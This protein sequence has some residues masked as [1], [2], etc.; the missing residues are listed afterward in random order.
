M[1]PNT[2][3][4][5]QKRKRADINAVAHLMRFGMQRGPHHY[6]GH[7][8]RACAGALVLQGEVWHR[9][10]LGEPQGK[11]QHLHK[12]L[13]LQAGMQDR[14]GQPCTRH[15]PFCFI[16]KPPNKIFSFLQFSSVSFG[17]CWLGT[18]H[19]LPVQICSSRPPA[20]V[21][22]LPSAQL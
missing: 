17:L 14:K 8:S 6:S 11:Q 21:P 4:H 9:A 5:T 18:P 22:A 19:Q 20:H 10:P 16:I 12:V 15:N 2:Y 3:T 13:M 7:K 1:L